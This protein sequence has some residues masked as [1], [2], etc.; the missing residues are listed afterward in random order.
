MESRGPL[1]RPV[2]RLARM[3]G[4]ALGGV[5]LAAAAVFVLLPLMGRAFVQGIGWLVTGCVWLATS[6]GVGVSLWDVLGTIGRAAAGGLATSTASVLLA[7][8]VIVGVAAL[9]WLQRLLESES[10]AEP[11]EESSQ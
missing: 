9:Y 3:A 11:E 6:I 1:E 5:S 8:L 2:A 7:V 4:L 10:P